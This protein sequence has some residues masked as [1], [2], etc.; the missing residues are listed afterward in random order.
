MDEHVHQNSDGNWEAPLPF[1]YPRQR[2]PNNRSHAFKRA[3]NLDVS[4]RR[5]EKKKEHFFQFMEKVLERKHAEIAPPLSQEEE[6]WYLPIF[7]VYHP[8]KPDKIRAV[9]DSSAKVCKYFS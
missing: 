1:R 4:L 7:G 9:F 2:L 6:R 5:D 3:M 8:R